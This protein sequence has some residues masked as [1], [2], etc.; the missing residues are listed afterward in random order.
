VRFK[1]PYYAPADEAAAESGDLIAANQEE[2]PAETPKQSESAVPE[3]ASS[4]APAG[5]GA[6]TG[7][8]TSGDGKEFFTVET[9]DGNVFYLIVDRQRTADNV[10]FL[11]AVTERDLLSLAEPG[12]GKSVNQAEPPPA[13]TAPAPEPTPPEPQKNGGI[14]KAAALIIIAALAVGAGYYIKILRP[15]KL[16]ISEAEDYEDETEGSGDFDASDIDEERGDEE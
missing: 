5:Q 9:A 3:G 14:A 16:G 1:N 2:I 10:Y 13:A 4:F 15:K 8:A 7:N 11:D 12:D 6:L